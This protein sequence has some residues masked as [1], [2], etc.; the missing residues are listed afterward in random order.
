[1]FKYFVPGEVVKNCHSHAKLVIF[2]PS[3]TPRVQ[4][5]TKPST[6][7]RQ[8]TTPRE[9]QEVRVEKSGL[10]MWRA[11]KFPFSAARQALCRS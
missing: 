2:G 5:F 8:A 10:F 7:Q 11:C 1:M 4:A 9:A 3:Q 6:S